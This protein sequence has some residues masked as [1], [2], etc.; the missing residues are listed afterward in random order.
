M[1]LFV[2]NDSYSVNIREIDEQHKKLIM[3]VNVLH[4]SMKE[5]KG[6]EVIGEIL[7]ELV[8]YTSYHFSFEESL[9]GKYGYAE[10]MMHVRQ[11]NDL[12]ADVK[13]FIEK[14]N[15]G[16]T[17]LSIDLLNFLKDWLTNHIVGTDK[18]YSA[19]LNSKGVS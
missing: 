7:D 4:T 12:I 3:L 2:W 15:T 5:G 6:K 17:V 13:K 19:F 18:K 10:A 16:S 11:H 8:K 14:Y 1:A 9:F